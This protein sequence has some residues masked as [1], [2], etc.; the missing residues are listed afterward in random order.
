MQVN[1]PRVRLCVA[2][3]SD[4]IGTPRKW[5]GETSM[6]VTAEAET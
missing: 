6:T 1:T 4:R 2:M 3:N 5:W